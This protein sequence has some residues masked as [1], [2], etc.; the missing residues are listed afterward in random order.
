MLLIMGA[1]I[2]WCEHICIHS[3]E[4]FSCDCNLGFTLNNDRKTCGRGNIIWASKPEN[5][6]LEVCEQKRRR[7]PCE[8]AQSDQRFCYSL[9]RKYRV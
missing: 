4:G 7:P 2:S 3:G 8:S 6:S 5:L 9:I 1:G